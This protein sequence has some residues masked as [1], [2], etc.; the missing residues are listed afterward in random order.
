MREPWGTKRQASGKAIC[1]ASWISGGRLP[2][3]TSTAVIEPASG[4]AGT[5][6]CET[7]CGWVEESKSSEEEYENGTGKDIVNEKEGE[8]DAKEKELEDNE[9][10]SEQGACNSE[11]ENLESDAW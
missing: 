1:E 11:T 10:M 4:S 8:D 2:S 9:R 7:A 5:R 3:S 6:S